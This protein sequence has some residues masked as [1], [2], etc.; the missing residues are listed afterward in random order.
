MAGLTQADLAERSG[1]SLPTIKRLE[2]GEGPL[3]VRLDTLQKLQ[4]ALEDAGILFLAENGHGP[5]VRLRKRT[6][7]PLGKWVDDLMREL[8]IEIEH[9]ANRPAAARK[10]IFTLY[11]EA[12]ASGLSDVEARSQVEEQIQSGKWRLVV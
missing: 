9:A 8:V 12:L 5:G 11:N 4:G 2:T 1:V 7:Q 3:G 10:T 6:P